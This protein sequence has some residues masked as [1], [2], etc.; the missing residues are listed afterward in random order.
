M[1]PLFEAWRLNDV[2]FTRITEVGKYL[3]MWKCG[4]LAECL[5]YAVVAKAKP[6]SGKATGNPVRL[7]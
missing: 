5:N 7:R 1:I 6:I 3:V 2:E 4:D